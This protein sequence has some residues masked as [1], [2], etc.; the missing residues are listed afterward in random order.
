MGPSL[1][2]SIEGVLEKTGTPLATGAMRI[3]VSVLRDEEVSA[4][5]MARTASGER[6][7]YVKTRQPPRLCSA[8]FPDGTTPPRRIWASGEWRLARRILTRD[9]EPGW[10]ASAGIYVC[11][12][13]L[14]QGLEDERLAALAHE[15]AARSVG[16]LAAYYPGPRSQWQELRDAMAKLPVGPGVTTQTSEQATA[17]RSLQEAELTPFALYFGLE[18]SAGIHRGPRPKELRLA[19]ANEAGA[20]PFDELVRESVGGDPV[21]ARGILAY[22][23]AF[24]RQMDELGRSPSVGQYAERW[25]VDIATATRERNSFAAVF[26]REEDP[27]GVANMLW[28]GADTA[29]SPFTRL[30]GVAVMRTTSFP[31]VIGYFVTSL[32]DEL[33]DPSG[34]RVMDA[35]IE[36][37]ESPPNPRTEINRFYALCARAVD[38][39]CADALEA[40]GDEPSLLGL[41]SLEPVHGEDTAAYT[42]QLL[43]EYRLANGR[44][45]GKDVL[46][47]TQKA[48][49]VA[50]S[51]RRAEPPETT[52]PYLDGIRWLA[53]ALIAAQ[54]AFG[55]DI[56]AEATRT[57]ARLDA[58]QL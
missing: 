5:R 21:R 53:K 46:L 52:K 48:L 56:A 43:G 17:E 39:W 31:T 45:A 50:A 1:A 49:R 3:L 15:L 35:A 34:A 19:L 38:V 40:M 22:V 26:P 8:L 4:E 9:A 24:G 30:L 23:E 54:R 6:D 36:F 42:E 14:E 18:A 33:R 20:K 32:A 12:L 47:A 28:E 44:K 27:T 25:D 7:T 29:N 51:L 11:D 16:P 41:R 58:V 13:I 2:Q 37:D 10:Q 57:T 55:I